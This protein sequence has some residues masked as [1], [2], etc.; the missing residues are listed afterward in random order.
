M[1]LDMLHHVVTLQDVGGDHSLLVRLVLDFTV[2][3]ICIVVGPTVIGL[4]LVEVLRDCLVASVG[5]A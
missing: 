1:V 5:V 2:D 4:V 3:H